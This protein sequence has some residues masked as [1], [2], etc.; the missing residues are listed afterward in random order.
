[1]NLPLLDLKKNNNFSPRIKNPFKLKKEDFEFNLL[2]KKKLK[3]KE[4]KEKLLN[5]SLFDRT[6]LSLENTKRSIPFTSRSIYSPRIPNSTQNFDPNTYIRPKSIREKIFE[7]RDTFLIQM[8]LDMKGKQ[9]SA[10]DEH[11]KETEINFFNQENFISNESSR[12]NRETDQIELELS[13]T[14]KI[15]ENMLLHRTELQKKLKIKKNQVSLLHSEIYKNQSNLEIFKEYYN[16]L[17]YL[18]PKNIKIKDYF[19]DINVI[20]D[21]IDSI[22]IDNRFLI[23]QIDKIEQDLSQN[24]TEINNLFSIEAFLN[25]L[26][27]KIINYNENINLIKEINNFD[28][29]E[30]IQIENELKNLSLKVSN[31]Y[32]NCFKKTSSVNPLESLA[33][34]ENKLENY[35]Q[36]LQTLSLDYVQI[37]TNE[38]YEKR[39]EELK[40]IEIEKR[41]LLLLEKK[42]LAIARAN[43]PIKKRNGRKLI[44]RSIPQINSKI[45]SIQL[46]NEKIELEKLNKLLYGPIFI[47]EEN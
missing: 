30:E 41:E 3:K 17:Y 5:L 35:Y 20:I 40:R 6:N 16:F 11:I 8:I 24:N 18:C 34:L 28:Y 14:I 31:L 46:Q 23:E 42:E 33:K 29:S 19:N 21:D 36:K 22:E 4:E 44:P 25:N 32:F 7:K 38:I 12:I 9:L 43:K 1:M 39:K 2:Y 10:I 26:E 15:A 27:K 37:K 13:R 45:T 47:E